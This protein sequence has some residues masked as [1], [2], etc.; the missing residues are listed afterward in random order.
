MADS[1]LRDGDAILTTHGFVFYVFGYEHPAD[2][3]HGF[4]KYVPRD[5]SDAF[6]IEWLDLGWRMEGRDIIRPL[7]LYSPE[8]YPMMVEGFREHFPEYL[9]HSEQLDRWMI[10]VPRDH[11]KRIFRPSE[12][13]KEI[14]GNGAGDSLEVDALELIQKLAETSGVS[15]DFFGVHGSIN[16][17]TSREESDID[18][19][20]Y[21][22]PNFRLVK[23]GL[24][25][26]EEA[27][28]LSLKRGDRAERRRLNSGAY[29]GRDFVVNATRLASEID[30]RPRSYRP[31]GPVEAECL[32]VRDDAAI[33]R[34]AVYGVQGCTSPDE[35]ENIG[36]VT[37]VVSM[38]GSYRD[39]V[40]RG[41][42]IKVRGFLEEVA[43]GDERW[44][45][46]VVGS[47]RAGEYLDW[48]EA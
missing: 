33:F 44:L 42:R 32:C 27:G 17:G 35:A 12:R 19:S 13:L 23:K 45:R 28:L 1:P 34:P 18:L 15:T 7:E 37:E 48:R 24:L 14:M 2:R 25:E 31:I 26:A 5:R 11:I 10:T 29:N 6:E 46:V 4:L 40:A 22:A 39:L 20:V 9:Y 8:S 43:R 47:G 30:D 3:Y 21:G 16:L 36:E 41:E 38:I